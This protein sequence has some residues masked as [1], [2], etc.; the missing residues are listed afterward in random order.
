MLKY[1]CAGLNINVTFVI[2]EHATQRVWTIT[3]QYSRIK[4]PPDLE[5]F[6][7][8]IVLNPVETHIHVACEN[9]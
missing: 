6:I 8:V 2:G 5:E 1:F 3:N 9:C 7:N 4:I